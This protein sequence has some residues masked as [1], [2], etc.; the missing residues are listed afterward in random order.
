MVFANLLKWMTK[1]DSIKIEEDDYEGDIHDPTMF[2]V[3]KRAKV[4]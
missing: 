1:S 3:R 2:P 4:F